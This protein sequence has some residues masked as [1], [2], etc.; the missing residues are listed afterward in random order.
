MPSEHAKFGSSTAKRTNNCSAWVELSRGVPNIESAAAAD[1]T[2]VHSIVEAWLLN[3]DERAGVE[4]AEEEHLELAADMMAAI[5]ATMVKYD[6]EEYEPEVRGTVAEDVF[7]TIDYIGKAGATLIIG[8][9]KSGKGFQVDAE[10]NDQILFAAWAI[11]ETDSDELQ[12]LI[13]GTDKLVGI[14]WQPS[15]DGEIHTKEWAFTWDEVDEWADNHEQMIAKARLDGNKP[16]PGDHC[17]FCPAAF[18]CPAKTGD[19]LRALQYNPTDI[20]I[21]AT[22]MAMVKDLKA[23]CNDVEKATY[24]ALEVGQK[25]TGWKLVA[26]RASRKWLDEAAAIK[27]LRRKLGGLKFVT[28]SKILGIGAMEKEIK[29]QKLS[30]DID[31]MGLTVKESSGTTIAPADDKRPAV[32]SSEAFAAALASVQ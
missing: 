12:N 15:R 9:V 4:G 31:E 6:V 18:K 27:T 29:R 19:A 14:I 24:N 2:I 8:D 10:R 13:E 16:T 22:N 3:P 11:G 5:D 20:E 21:L 1:G 25:V 28:T 17:A 26:S 30:I 32:L 23:W 7:G